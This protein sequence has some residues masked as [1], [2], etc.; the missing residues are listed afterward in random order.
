MKCPYDWGAFLEG[1]AAGL[2]VLWLELWFA[3]KRREKNG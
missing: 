1:L 3:R 2:F